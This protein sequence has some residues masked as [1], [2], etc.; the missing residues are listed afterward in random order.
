[1]Q[2]TNAEK[3]RRNPRLGHPRRER[4]AAETVGRHAAARPMKITPAAK[5]ISCGINGRATSMKGGRM[6]VKNTITLGLAICTVKP[7]RNAELPSLT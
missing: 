1:M 3:P 4:R 7:S 5:A 2:P 6:A